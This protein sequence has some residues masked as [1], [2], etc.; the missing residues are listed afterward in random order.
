MVKANSAH[1]HSSFP[2]LLYK[3]MQK[4]IIFS[5]K[6]KFQKKKKDSIYTEPQDKSNEKTHPGPL[7]A[8]LFKLFKIKPTLYTDHKES[9]DIALH[10]ISYV[11]LTGL[12]YNPV[13]VKASVL[14]F[15]S[16][17]LRIQGPNIYSMQFNSVM[18]FPSQ[19][20]ATLHCTHSQR[21]S[22][23]FEFCLFTVT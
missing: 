3:L 19:S 23:L 20:V 22:A 18:K 11:L 16:F 4:K 7:R 13:K 17:P 10:P 21:I 6:S 2:T 8:L 14:L 15:L 12:L 1:L 9:E 5:I